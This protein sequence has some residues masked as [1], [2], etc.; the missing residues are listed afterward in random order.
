MSRLLFLTVLLAAGFSARAQQSPA[1]APSQPMPTE[2]PPPDSAKIADMP[3]HMQPPTPDSAAKPASGAHPRSTAATSLSVQPKLNPNSP[4]TY[5]KKAVQ[6]Q[7]KQSQ[8]AITKRRRQTARYQA[9]REGDR[10]RG[11]RR[12]EKGKTVTATSQR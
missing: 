5:N 8:K 9:V 11:I 2:I 12:M 6:A 1:V 7:Q 4:G 10:I 3:L